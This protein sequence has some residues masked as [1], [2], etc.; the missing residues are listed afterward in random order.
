M[1]QEILLCYFIV[2]EAKEGR[3]ASLPKIEESKSNE[4]FKLKT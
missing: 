3:M 4:L 2:R 1:I